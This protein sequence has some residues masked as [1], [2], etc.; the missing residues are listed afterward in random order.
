MHLSFSLKSLHLYNR[1]YNNDILERLLVNSA[2]ETLHLTLPGSA[3]PYAP[4]ISQFPR[5][6]K[7]LRQL[8]LFHKPST[9]LLTV[10]H[11]CTRL[12]ELKCH[13]DVDLGEL[14]AA[15]PH[16]QP[17]LG[18]LELQIEYNARSMVSL[19]CR[20]LLMPTPAQSPLDK[21]LPP[22]RRTDG[23]LTSLKILIIRGTSQSELQMLGLHSFLEACDLMEPRIEL[24][25]PDEEWSMRERQRRLFV[26]SAS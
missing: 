3:S 22:Q 25:L 16:E 24:V 13:A 17:S 14:L 2:L 1:T 20:T 21:R 12:Q 5:I 11:T 23:P 6:A 7:S 18:K 4:L 26:E 8:Q 9:A 10:L 15:L 19:L